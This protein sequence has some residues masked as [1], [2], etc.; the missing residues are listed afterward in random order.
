MMQAG[1]DY[2]VEVVTAYE[3]RRVGQ[4]FHPPALLR[5]R[6]VKLGLVRR[7]DGPQAPPVSTETTTTA[8]PVL[9]PLQ[10]A[11]VPSSAESAEP[12]IKKPRGGRGGL[13]T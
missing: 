10:S 8:Q 13:F 11:A 2:G 12:K 7:L 1:K 4:V 6:L 5:D 9:Q 3:F